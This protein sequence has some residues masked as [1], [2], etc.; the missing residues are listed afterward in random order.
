[1]SANEGTACATRSDR[2]A[3]PKS[4]RRERPD[5]LAGIED[6][7]GEAVAATLQYRTNHRDLLRLVDQ[8]DAEQFIKHPRQRIER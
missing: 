3:P 7:L 2:T 5:P 1:M 4:T 8:R 6:A